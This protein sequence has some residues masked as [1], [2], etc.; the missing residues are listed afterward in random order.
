MNLSQHVEC[1]DTLQSH[2][3]REKGYTRLVY[4]C[5]MICMA[6]STRQNLAGGLEYRQACILQLAAERDPP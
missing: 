6:R 5:E 3:L 2:R 1:R 4:I